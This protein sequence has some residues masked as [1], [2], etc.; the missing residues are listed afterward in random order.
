VLFLIAFFACYENLS[1]GLH[2][3][4][5]CRPSHPACPTVQ[6]ASTALLSFTAT[7]ESGNQE[8]CEAS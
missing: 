8:G 3:W 2:A 4:S 7:L 6:N 5:G 1:F